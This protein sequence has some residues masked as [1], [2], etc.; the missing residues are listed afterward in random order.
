MINRDKA[1]NHIKSALVDSVG[2]REAENIGKYYV[3]S[4]VE[5]P[6][7]EQQLLSDIEKM[8]DGVP[9]QYITSNSFFYGKRFLV[10]EHVLIPRPETEELVHFIIQDYKSSSHPDLTILD[11]GVGSGCILLSVVS[12]LGIKG[13]GIDVSPE[14]LSVCQVNAHALECNVGLYCS[15]I[16]VEL[17][18]KQP[19]DIIVSNPPYILKSEKQGRVQDSVDRYEPS[20]ALYVENNDPLIFYKRIIE[21]S[22]EML[23]DGGHLYFET[24]DLFHDELR[25]LVDSTE[26]EYEF[27]KDLQGNW[28]M[29][30]IYY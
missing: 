20:I 3:D 14:A 1:L 23:V 24:S 18:I 11:I 9:V 30:K 12:E 13:I 6:I 25:E 21:L 29:L 2:L 16:L 10:N 4:K 15:N 17:P 19:V 28:R 7:M 8:A 26:K 22:E 5:W 27:K